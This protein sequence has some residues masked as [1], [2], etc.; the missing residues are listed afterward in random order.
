MIGRK[1]AGSLR[2]LS[3]VGNSVLPT[4]KAI[5]DVTGHPVAGYAVEGIRHG[6]NA[7]NNMRE[8]VESKT[9]SKVDYVRNMLY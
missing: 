8:K 6:V 3:D 2:T 5:V 1:A 7:L 9:Y 4:V